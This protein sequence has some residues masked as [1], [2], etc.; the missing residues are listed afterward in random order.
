MEHQNAAHLD[1]RQRKTR[2]LLV[3]ALAQLL[4]EKPF[5]ELSVTDICQ[6]AMVRAGS[7]ALSPAD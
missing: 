3:E 5:Q 2:K 4:E 6:R 7:A 1:L